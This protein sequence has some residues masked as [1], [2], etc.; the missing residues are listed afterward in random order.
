MLPRQEKK[1]NQM[2]KSILGAV[3][4]MIAA[5]V[6]Q[7]SAQTNWD[8]NA[9]FILTSQSSGGH[10]ALSSKVLIADLIGASVTNSGTIITTNVA[11]SVTDTNLLPGT[12]F[13][14]FHTNTIVSGTNTNTVVLSQTS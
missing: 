13:P 5:G 9:N 2:R 3:I 14:A 12:N 6:V 11:T 8:Q 7:S 10:A 4:G 1:G